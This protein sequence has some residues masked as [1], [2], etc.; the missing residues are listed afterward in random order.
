MKPNGSACRTLRRVLAFVFTLT[1]LVGDAYPQAGT[2][3]I[4]GSVTDELEGLIVNATAFARDAKGAEKSAKTNS[5]GVYEFRNLAP[6]VYSVRVVA[7]GFGVFEEKGVEVAPRRVTNLNVQLR[8][9]LEQETM[10]VEDKGVS[11]DADRNADA[12][13]LRGQDLAALPADPQALAASLQAMAGPPAEGQT[14]AQITVDGF[15]NGQMPPKEAIREVRINQ[16]PY[17]AENEYPG[18]GGIEIFTQP[19]SDKWHGAA[20]FGFNDESLNSRNPFTLR[21]A[22]YQQRSYNTSLSG[23]IV[24]K[25]ASFAVNFNRFASDANSVVNAT[26]LDP[27]SLLPV[28]FNRTFVT[29][30]VFTYSNVRGDLKINKAHTLV[31]NYSYNRSTQDLQGIGGF[32]LPSRAYRG[33]S[34]Y[35]TSQLT[36]TALLNERT[37]NETRFQFSR[38]SSRQTGDASEPALNVQDSFFGGGA[39]VGNS[40]SRQQRMELHNFTSWASGNHF[41]KLGGR[42][43]DVRLRSVSQSNF[44]GTFTFAGG[45]GPRL[46]DANQVVVG[47]DGQP[48][49]VELSSL[50]RYRRTLLF[51]RKGMS[52]AQIRSLGGGATQFSI[53]GGNPEA[54]VAQTDISLY[55]QDDWKI[56]QNLTVSPGLR[57]EN[58]TN[59]SSPLNFAPRIGFAWAPSFG[60][61]KKTTPTADAKTGT[62]DAKNAAP[63]SAPTAPGATKAAGAATQ[64]ATAAAASKP[65]APP[66]GPPKT[67]FRG[68]VGIFYNRVSEDLTLQALRFNGVNQQQ[69]VVADPSVLDLF[70]AVPALSLLN[71]FALPQTRR[72]ISPLLDPS[73]SLRASFSVERLLP[74]G[75]KLTLGY[76][77]AHTLRTQRAVNI[78]APL[79]GT[80]NP[81]VPSSGVRPLGQGAGN[82]LEYES[83][84]KSINNSLSVSVNGR[85]RKLNFWST[86]TLG[87]SMSRDGGTSGS[88]FD[89]YDFGGEWGRSNFDTRHF[90]WAGG[91]YSAPHGF[92]LNT[93]IVANSGTPFNITTGRDTNG[94]TFFTERPAFATDLSKPGVVVTPLGAFDPNPAPGQA[95]IP[96]NFAQGPSFFSVNVGVEKSIKFG[97]ALQPKEGAAAG[98]SNANIVTSANSRQTPPKKQ[99][100]QRPYQLSLSLYANNILNHTNRANPVGNM[101]S[102]YF[103]RS[104]APSNQFIFG[105][106]G[107]ASGNRQLLLRLRVSF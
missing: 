75:V 53:A 26:I 56:R 65:P 95:V 83:N 44:G 29:P 105:P 21:R 12:L 40:S 57:Y 27:S 73:D 42:V 96:R 70:P 33:A 25:R 45:F 79:A 6:G 69:F 77:H 67:V 24:A 43:R 101:A 55:V 32:S 34:S 30:Q 58:Q 85:I 47:P 91:N 18:W 86:Y 90:L 31:G 92:S 54:R 11:T 66:P 28:L 100:V 5:A 102:P 59:V 76:S 35:H 64:T 63:A 80:Y 104:T 3:S 107:S 88:P 37:V 23:P 39:Q 49:V 19:G 82:V 22:P 52:A 94:D 72:V 99:P 1:A 20:G 13:V 8:V 51:A 93:F 16:N 9:T 4:R 48:V 7:P 2:G 36:E 103:L 81:Q 87:K 17:A 97:R 15:S 89:P 84:G 60:G 50:E 62:A 106:G 98:V 41:V 71:S 68:G 10:T 46:D 74:A 14:G 78:N 61:M 38:G